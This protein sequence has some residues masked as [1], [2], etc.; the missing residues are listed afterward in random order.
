M[1]DYLWDKGGPP[2]PETERLEELL[3]Q[4]RHSGREPEWPAPG[5][6]RFRMSVAR[7]LAAA[8]VVVLAIGATLWIREQRR[9]GWKISP[10]EGAPLIAGSPLRQEGVLKIGDWLETGSGARA[11]LSIGQI[12]YVRIDPGT[13]LRIAQARPTEHRLALER[14][15]IQARIWAPP[16]LFFV[17]LPSAVAIDLGCAYTLEVDEEGNGRIHVSLGWVGFEADGLESLIPAG[18]ACQTR[19]DTGPG[20]PYFL[21]AAKPFVAAVERWNSGSREPEDLE[22]ILSQAR[23]RDAM[24]LWHLL[25]RVALADRGRLFDRMR[26]LTPPPG[27]V[28]RDGVLVLERE[29]LESWWDSLGLGETNWWK[30]WKRRWP[31]SVR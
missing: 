8:A 14:G 5:Q 16:R 24:T 31:P 22:T 30:L 18:A 17:N 15:R 13:R 21:D 11:E 26:E 1:P 19:R 20:I 28:T 9:G 2:D 29:M 4:F 3:G 10:L 7:W 12:G 25:P 6:P 27:K 23:P